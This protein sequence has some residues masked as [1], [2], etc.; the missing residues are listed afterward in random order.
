MTT[1]RRPLSLAVVLMLASAARTASAAPAWGANC[2]SCHGVSQPETLYVFGEDAETDP[3]ESQTGAPDRGLLRTFW[4][5][6]GGTT[7]LLVG[8]EGLAPDDT[9]AVELKRFRFSGVVSGGTLDQTGDCG[10]AQWVNPGDHYTHTT[11]AHRWGT[12]S[13]PETFSFDINVQSSTPED[14]F[15]LVLAVAG[16]RAADGALFYDEEHF[17]LQVAQFQPYPYPGDLDDD[18]DVDLVDHARFEVCLSGPGATARPPE[19]DPTDFLEADLNGDGDVDLRDFA[20]FSR[21]F[22]GS[23]PPGSGERRR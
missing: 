6:P 16:K 2:A 15:D 1:M 8:V 10:W 4:V 14:C 9:Y 17:Y 19:C 5:S 20:A 21:Y 3:D 22:L 7:P 23:H 11:I 13:G 12:G 18:G